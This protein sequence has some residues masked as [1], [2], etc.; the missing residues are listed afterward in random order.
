MSGQ[1]S[2]LEEQSVPFMSE[3]TFPLENNLSENDSPENVQLETFSIGS[4]HDAQQKA[5]DVRRR[6]YVSHFLSTWNSRV[7][8]FGAVLFL[9]QF[10]PGTLLPAS[11]YALVRAASAICFAHLV[12]NYIDS[13]DRL[14]VTSGLFQS[15]DMMTQEQQSDNDQR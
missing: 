10:F 13:E 4:D 8:E 2:A 14:K 5:V 1:Q 15:A 9:A 3:D 7:F 11:V 12:G 6:L